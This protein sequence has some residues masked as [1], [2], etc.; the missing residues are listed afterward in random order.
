MKRFNVQFDNP[1]IDNLLRRI[2]WST[3]SN[4]L[5]RSVYIT[6]SWPLLSSVSAICWDMQTKFVFVDLPTENPCWKGGK[7]MSNRM[8]RRSLFEPLKLISASFLKKSYHFSRTAN[9]KYENF[10]DLQK[11]YHKLNIKNLASV[12]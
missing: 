12:P 3:L 1:N 7:L 9:S 8:C 10:L 4:A 11:F 2:R 5:L 6:S